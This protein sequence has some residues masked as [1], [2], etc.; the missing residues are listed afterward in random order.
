MRL[1]MLRSEN[2]STKRHLVLRCVDVALRG[3]RRCVGAGVLD[4]ALRERVV[5]W[6]R[7]C[8]GA[9]VALSSKMPFQ[10]NCFL[11]ASNL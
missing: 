4:A 10:E 6:V 3:C 11:G 5:I 7:H 2:L 8:V 1:S 9:D